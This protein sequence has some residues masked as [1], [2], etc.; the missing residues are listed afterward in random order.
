MFALLFQTAKLYKNEL[1]PIY[2]IPQCAQGSLCCLL[3]LNIH[4][5]NAVSKLKESYKGSN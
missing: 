4:M 2:V 3:Q 1:P 5:D